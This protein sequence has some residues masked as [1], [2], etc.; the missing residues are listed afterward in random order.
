MSQRDPF[1]A[2]VARIE[3]VEAIVTAEAVLLRAQDVLRRVRRELFSRVRS[4]ESTKLLADINDL[5]GD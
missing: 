3:I 1:G 5:L 2:A 4:P